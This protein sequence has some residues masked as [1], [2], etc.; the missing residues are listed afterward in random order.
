MI[1][2][3]KTREV[4][5]GSEIGT[6]FHI[7]FEAMKAE[8][9]F[10]NLRFVDTGAVA[11]TVAAMEGGQIELAMAPLG[12]IKDSVDA[13]RFNVLAFFSGKERSQFAPEIPTMLELGVDL[14]MPKFFFMA[15]P[16]NTPQDRA[17][18]IRSALKE[19]AKDPAFIEEA[20][21]LFYT[22]GY[23][24]PEDIY[25]MERINYELMTKYI[26]AIRD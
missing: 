2:A 22:P 25:E 5:F 18:V 4:L 12:S 23:L 13:G 17:E 10:P 26:S 3:A 14:Y 6:S 21:N 15:M 1:N 9:G 20:K 7:A 8:L 16:K 19:I 24:S 11:P